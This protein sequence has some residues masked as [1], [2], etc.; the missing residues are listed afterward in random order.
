MGVWSMAWQ[1]V[2]SARPSFLFGSHFLFS[3]GE[4]GKG[5]FNWTKKLE[6]AHSRSWGWGRQQPV[7]LRCVNG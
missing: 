2:G 5:I 3:V 1:G 6:E 4:W 7:A